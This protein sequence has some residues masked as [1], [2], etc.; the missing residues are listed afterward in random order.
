[1]DRRDDIQNLYGAIHHKVTGELLYLMDGLF[2]NLEEALNDFAIRHPGEESHCLV[3]LRAMSSKRSTLIHLIAERMQKALDCWHNGQELDTREGNDELQSAAGEMAKKSTGHFDLL[4]KLI[5]QRSQVAF[6]THTTQMQVPI[7]PRHVAF[8]F[9]GSC[10]DLRF[11]AKDIDILKEL[12]ERFVL[13][14]LGTTYGEC[15]HRLKSEGF[16]TEQ[17]LTHAVSA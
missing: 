15:N 11:G 3:L 4:L 2:Q 12:F 8:A 17:E 1:M 9:L 14:R 6:D 7:S 10:H 16:L 5:D 13:D